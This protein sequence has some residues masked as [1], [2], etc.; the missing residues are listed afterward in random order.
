MDSARGNQ[1][2]RLSS[3]LGLAAGV[4]MLHAKFSWPGWLVIALCIL[5]L[6][7]QRP[8][9]SASAT[10]RLETRRS[11]W[12]LLLAVMA[13][14]ACLRVWDLAQVPPGCWYDEAENGLET[15]RILQGDFFL[16]TPRNNGRGAI[17]FFWTAPFFRFFGENVFSLRLAAAVIGVLTLPA[18]WMLFHRLAGPALALPAT[19]VLACSR[20]HI[21]VSR[22][23]FDAVMTPLFDIL[24]VYALLRAWPAGSYFWFALAGVVAALAN[25]GYA[26]SRLTPLLALFT[27]LLLSKDGCSRQQ[28]RG[29]LFLVL[30][31]AV[32]LFPLLSGFL[33][34]PRLLVNRSSQVIIPLTR[35]VKPLLHN[36]RTTL[37]MLHERGDAI[38]RHN[39]PGKPM[40]DP[41]AGTLLLIGL[42]AAWRGKLAFGKWLALGWM[43][44][45]LFFGSLLT[46]PAPHAL[47]TLSAL[48]PICLLA[49]GGWQVLLAAHAITARRSM[50][51]TVVLCAGMAGFTVH[52]YFF[53]YAR[54]PQI[55]QSFSATAYAVGLYLREHAGTM[56]YF[57]SDAI[58]LQV[59]QFVAYPRT[60][61][62]RPFIPRQTFAA[63]DPSAA[64]IVRTDDEVPWLDGRTDYRRQRID[65]AG[66]ETFI[67]FFPATAQ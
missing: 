13:A 20:W 60:P 15:L 1:F 40:L 11:E 58:S 9:L 28:Q 56:P 7:R 55:R 52:D 43:A 44:L 35:P 57:I 62:V 67:L 59:V 10:P 63:E 17:Q 27:I 29:L 51:L 18:A 37:R 38:P 45:V 30:V 19:A 36:L 66:G 14:G 22:I 50:L 64:Y 23:G 33:A 49:A 26:A 31:F 39:L 54:N 24:L 53:L 42:C 6:C 12:I 2:L 32:L 47:R 3:Y 61:Q 48:L 34:N 25:Y 4:V 8:A 5:L 41:I 46:Q 16:F 21:T 65:A